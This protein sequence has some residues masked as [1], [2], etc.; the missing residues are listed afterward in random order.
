[1]K[2]I[3]SALAVVFA[4]AAFLSFTTPGHQVLNILGFAMADPC[5]GNNC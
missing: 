3:I 1:M 4:A 5:N 2:K